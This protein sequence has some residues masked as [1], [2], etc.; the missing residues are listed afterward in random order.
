VTGAIVMAVVGQF[1]DG[2]ARPMILG[3]ALCAMTALA[4]ARVTLGGKKA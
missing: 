4:I 1:V 3:I 2:S